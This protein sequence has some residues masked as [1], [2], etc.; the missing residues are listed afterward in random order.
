MCKR[1]GINSGCRKRPYL[2]GRRTGSKN[3]VTV[4][5]FFAW[6]KALRKLHHKNSVT[7]GCKRAFQYATKVLN[8]KA[9][10]TWLGVDMPT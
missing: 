9:S 8:P 4:L 3:V 1:R 10:Q 5:N 6:E 7:L 2:G